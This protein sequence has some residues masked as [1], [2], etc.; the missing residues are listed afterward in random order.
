MLGAIL[1]GL[2]GAGS[3]L[4]GS[5]MNAAS[6]EA[7]NARLIADKEQDRALQREFA[8]TG[9]QWK[10]Q[11]AKQAGI[12]PLY[13]LG[14]NTV[15]YAPS[16]LN[17][18]PSNPGTGIAAAGQDISR[19]INA[20]RTADQREDAYTS[21]VK[22]LT[23]QKMG[24]ENDLLASQIRKLGPP[25]PPMPVPGG[26]V[27][28]AAQFEDRPR[29]M[30]GGNEINTDPKTSNTEDFEKR[31]GELTDWTVGPYVLWRDYMNHVRP[32]DLS[33]QQISN[34]GNLFA[35]G[36]RQYYQVKERLRS[37]NPGTWS[38]Y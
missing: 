26:P 17:L 8:Q 15:S 19:A 25:T 16:A 33:Q 13:A 31:Y 6:N 22:A 5:S 12:H 18:T 27:P 9:I 11:D 30:L 34:Y 36:A 23:L 35:R 10:V 3:S 21:S 4:I 1:S 29:L 37:A 14:A 20:T 32:P 7:N 38:N 24:L 2:I 28:Q